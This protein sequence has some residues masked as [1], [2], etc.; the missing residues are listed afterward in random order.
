MSELTITTSAGAVSRKTAFMLAT[1]PRFSARRTYSTGSRSATS[2]AIRLRERLDL[3]VRARVVGD[4]HVRAGR[5]VLDDA[6]QALLEQLA[7]PEHGDADDRLAAHVRV[8]RRC[9]ARAV[10]DDVAQHAHEQR[11]C[12]NGISR[13]CAPPIASAALGAS[14]VD[15]RVARLLDDHRERVAHDQVLQPDLGDLLDRIEDRRPVEGDLQHHL[16][17]RLDVAVAHEQRRE[18]RADTRREDAEADDQRED[19]EPAPARLDTRG[20]DED[21]HRDEVQDR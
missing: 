20:E 1:K 15:D 12:P 6:A 18:H 7:R 4:E 9:G 2:S 21:H 3:R 10:E 17:D 13:Y 5:R 14:G 11:G 19:L 8:P 16:P